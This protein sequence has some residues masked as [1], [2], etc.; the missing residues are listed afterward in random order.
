M[1]RDEDALIEINRAFY[2]AFRN[3]DL[4]ALDALWAHAHEVAVIHP[5]WPLVEGRAAVLESWRRILEGP[6]PPQIRCAEERAF[7]LGDAAFV[8]CREQLEGGDLIATN[9]F[10]RE[11]G[12]WRL[13]HHQAGPVPPATAGP[14]NGGTVH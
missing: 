10:A 7:V 3:R 6:S 2:D 12:S 4:E 9:V 8:I 5:G 1:V 11:A 14:V 13:V